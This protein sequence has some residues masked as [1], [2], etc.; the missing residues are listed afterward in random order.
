[1]ANNNKKSGGA[2]LDVVCNLTFVAAAIVLLVALCVNNNNATAFNVLILVGCAVCAL[3]AIVVLVRAIMV[4]C[5][6]LN[7][8]SPEYKNAITRTVFMGIVFALSVLGLVY[9]IIELLK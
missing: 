8:R 6:K 9:A 5:G 4:L 7:H 2:V 3:A 1:M